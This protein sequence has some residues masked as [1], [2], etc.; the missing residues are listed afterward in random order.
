MS[1]VI[2]LILKTHKFEQKTQWEKEKYSITKKPK[3]K[4]QRKGKHL[5]LYHDTRCLYSMKV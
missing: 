5:N 1:Q 4:P 3:L 2:I